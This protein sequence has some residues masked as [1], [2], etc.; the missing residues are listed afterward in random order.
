MNA[1]TTSLD[2]PFLARVGDTFR[3]AAEVL[4][5]ACAGMAC[6]RE[7]KRLFALS[8]EEL[9]RRGLARNRIIDHAF[10]RFLAS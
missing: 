6:A 10:A 3:A 2:R 4:A 7:A 1:H 8:D 9:A 5:D